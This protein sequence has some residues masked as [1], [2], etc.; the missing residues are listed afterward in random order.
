[1]LKWE[2]KKNSWGEDPN[3]CNKNGGRKGCITNWCFRED[4]M[5]YYYDS[6]RIV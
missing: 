1:M 4:W 5:P 2:A 6:L 3:S